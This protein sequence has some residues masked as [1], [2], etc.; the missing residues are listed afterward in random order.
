MR[1]K[2]L[3]G[4]TKQNLEFI[5]EQVLKITGLD[6]IKTKSRA[7]EY[8]LGRYLFCWLAREYTPYSYATIGSYI[9]RDHATVMHNAKSCEWEVQWN[10]NL[11]TQHES[12]KII[13]ENQFLNSVEKSK[14]EDRIKLLEQ[15]LT[16][17][18]KQYNESFNPKRKN[19]E[20][21]EEIRSQSIQLDPACI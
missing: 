21:L 7:H 8:V 1:G 4:I 3:D 15:Q 12:L 20:D 14:L 5:E 9:D 19:A 16:K 2:I 18:K 13:M 17:L 10:K 6:V 11:H